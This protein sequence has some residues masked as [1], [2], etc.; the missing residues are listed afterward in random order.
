MEEVV[1]G[2]IDEIRLAAFVVILKEGQR[3]FVGFGD[4]GEACQHFDI[5]FFL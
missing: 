5:G 4:A 2:I 1:G 3:L